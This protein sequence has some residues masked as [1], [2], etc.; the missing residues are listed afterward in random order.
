MKVGIFFSKNFIPIFINN[1]FNRY[2]QWTYLIEII[3]ESWNIFFRK[4]LFPFL[5][6]FVLTDILNEIINESWNIFF[7]KILFP[8]LLII[9]LIDI[10]NKIINKIFNEI[11]NIFFRKILFHFY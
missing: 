8:F 2:T 7:R 4:I 11:Y 5:L 3:N 6:I 9:I 1:C 10:L